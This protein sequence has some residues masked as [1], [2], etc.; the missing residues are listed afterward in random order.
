MGKPLFQLVN[1]PFLMIP[2]FL[3]FKHPRIHSVV[4]SMTIPFVPRL[5]SRSRQDPNP[6][7]PSG[8]EDMGAP[9]A[10]ASCGAK[11]GGTVLGVAKAR[12]PAGVLQR[13]GVNGHG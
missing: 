13:L 2:M 12:L 1:P 11:C 9:L 3:I 5:K 7:G 8:A 4:K 6:R 10:S